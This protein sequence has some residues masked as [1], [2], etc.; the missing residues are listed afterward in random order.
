MVQLLALKR[1]DS[2]SYHPDVILWGETLTLLK[3]CMIT[4]HA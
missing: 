4:W 3:L 2:D 1:L